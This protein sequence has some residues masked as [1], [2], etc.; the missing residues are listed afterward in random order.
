MPIN[1]VKTQ[2]LIALSNALCALKLQSFPTQLRQSP[3]LGHKMP[4]LCKMC[5]PNVVKSQIFSNVDQLRDSGRE[6]RISR[7][8]NTSLTFHTN[9]ESWKIP[10][11]IRVPPNLASDLFPGRGLGI[12]EYIG[13]ELT[14]QRTE[15]EEKLLQQKSFVLNRPELWIFRGVKEKC[16][17]TFDMTSSRVPAAIFKL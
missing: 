2:V 4:P 13:C 17:H 12:C 1:S 6:S 8:I 3:P 10:W 14:H 9:G 7:K 16:L 11:H 5:D 15:S